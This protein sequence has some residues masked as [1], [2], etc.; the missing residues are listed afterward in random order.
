[1]FGLQGLADL[2]MDSV[3]LQ[4]ERMLEV[5]QRNLDEAEERELSNK[6]GPLFPKS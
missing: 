6:V 5:L 1:M 2:L 3:E 4:G